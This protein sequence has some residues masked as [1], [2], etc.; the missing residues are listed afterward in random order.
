MLLLLAWAGSLAAQTFR[1]SISG[2]VVDPSG[3]VVPN[4][5]IAATHEATGV[6]YTTKTSSSG[7]YLFED[8][9][10]GPFTVSAAARGFQPL[11]VKGVIV[12]AGAVRALPLQLSI[13]ANN[14]T[15]NVTA[16][17]LALDT[18]SSTQTTD[19]PSETIED[20]P[21]AGR[22][23]LQA[24]SLA[25]GTAGYTNNSFTTSVNGTRVEQVNY[26]INGTDNNDPFRDQTAANQNGVEGIP[27][28]LFPIDA[29]EELSLQTQSTPE[30]GRNPGGVLNLVVKSG[31]NELHGS[32]FYFK[33]D[34]SLSASSPFLQKGQS[35]PENTSS[36]WG[37]SVGGPIIK[38]RTFF[39]LSYE[40]QNF[41]VAPGETSTEPG[42]GYVSA[43]EEVLA[44]A[45]Q[46]YGTYS[47]VSVNSVSLALLNGLWPNNALAV[48][49]ASTNN[50][51]STDNEYGYSHNLVA[52][53]DHKINDKNTLSVSGYIGE[54][55][56]VAP[57][58]SDLKPYYCAGPLHVH[59]YSAVWNSTLSTRLTNQLLLGVDAYN[60]TF[61]D[62]K[63]SQ[64]ISSYG[65]VTESPFTGSPQI[66]IGNFD[67]IG[68]VGIAGRVSVTGHVTD[69]L[70]LVIGK[71]QF[72]AGGEFRK[73]QTNEFYYNNALGSLDFSGNVG[74][75]Y[76][77]SNPKA[78]SYVKA[79]ADFLAGYSDSS[80]IAYGDA[81]RYLY[82]NTTSVFANDTWQLNPRLTVNYGVRWDYL[83][84]VHDGF[85]DLATFDPAHGGVAYQGNQIGSLY[86]GDWVNFSPRVGF[87]YQPS[88]ARAG[89]VVR[90]GF[91]IF[92]DTPAFDNFVQSTSKNGGAGGIQDDP[93]GPKQ[94]NNYTQGIATITSGQDF[95]GGAALSNSTSLFSV[96][97]KF[98]T[99]RDVT[100]NLQIEK[101]L[102]ER[103]IAQI[104]YVG[105]IGKHLADTVDINRSAPNASGS[106][107]QSLRPYYTAYSGAYS[108]YTF[109]NQLN[110]DAV[111][112]Y[113]ALQAVLKLSA[114]HGLGGQASYTWSHNLDDSSSARAKQDWPQDSLNLKGNYGNADTDQH[115]SLSAVLSYAIPS[116]QAGPKWLTSGWSVNGLVSIHTGNPFTIATNS[117][118][119]SGTGDKTQFADVVG[120]P[121]AGVSH[122]RVT[123]S[124][125][126]V[127]E[128]WINTSAFKVPAAGTFGNQRRN[129]YFGPGYADIDTSVF[130]D[131]LL[132][133]RIKAQ[134][135]AELFNTFNRVNLGNPST[136]YGSSFG[137]IGSTVGAYNSSPGI[138]PGE[139]F[140][141]QLGLKVS[142]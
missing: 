78:D 90:G 77:S 121:F 74:P 115:H 44:N 43:A 130:K 136:G 134:F 16:T 14:T 9:P 108:E 27:G 23:F 97:Q 21:I 118:D 66:T 73:V 17:A 31:S 6:T 123:A 59:N 75:W 101:S 15:V 49:S 36:N 40:K 125:G 124:D 34:T 94:V 46:Q 113:N 76:N 2:T 1:G 52:K 110:T 138:G 65:L 48:A 142:F 109:I 116:S 120:K 51:F 3:A 28:V 133:E 131:V 61:H 92:Y 135:R 8:L 24:A 71:H 55:N 141:A 25:P 122:K 80:S 54:G 84:P 98:R 35:K 93:G 117:Q 38:H 96:S 19:I 85:K 10:L 83:T 103:A 102:G 129:Q 68:L 60:Q 42:T 88:S 114:W 70:S 89:I 82:Q 53:I 18:Q 100:Y 69:A 47:P 20:E 119:S 95:F 127:Y 99:P 64:N 22:S 87:S 79:L 140:N 57:V 106:A 7:Q 128:Q 50:F 112:N 41:S 107:V 56:Q 81:T 62:F 111:S 37:G 4:L 105:L 45:N 104:G 12:N 29:V 137:T 126:S 33:R 139:P 72:R 5:T 91:G 63:H 11:A 32:G 132:K 13:S 58:G 67:P 26:Q 30:T 39:F 86:P